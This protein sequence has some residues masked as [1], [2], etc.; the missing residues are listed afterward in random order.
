[1][2]VEADILARDST[3]KSIL[4]AE[5][6][7]RENLSPDVAA[8]LRRNLAAN[9]LLVPANYFLLASQDVA[10]L[11]KDADSSSPEMPP[12][13]QFP[14]SNIIARYLPRIGPHE[15][16]SGSVLQMLLEQWLQDLSR[17]KGNGHAEPESTLAPT[18]LLEALRGTVVLAHARL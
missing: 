8:N 3:G 11:W 16:L 14:M 12:T 10:Y 7:N 4:V 13:V 15:R 6:K 18:G 17:A 9:N 5:I 1:V 2:T